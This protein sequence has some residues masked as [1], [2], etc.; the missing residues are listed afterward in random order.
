MRKVYKYRKIK[1]TN[2]QKE[3]RE[4]LNKLKDDIS[5]KIN[6]FQKKNKN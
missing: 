1:G 6:E 3:K 2:K 4:K 5:F